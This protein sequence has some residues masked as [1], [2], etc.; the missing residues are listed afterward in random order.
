MCVPQS[1]KHWLILYED[2]SKRANHKKVELSNQISTKIRPAARIIQT[3]GSELIGDPYAAIIELVKNAFDAD[4]NKVEIVF[5]YD[6]SQEKLK[7]RIVDD[8]HGMTE[9]V[10]L[11][12]WLVP[13]TK[14]KLNIEKSP[15]GRIFQ[16]KK[17]IGRFAAALLGQEL[18]LNTT[19]ENHITTQILVDWDIFETSDFLDE[20]EILVEV[21]NTQENPGTELII[22]AKDEKVSQ[23][24]KTE[25]GILTKELRKLKSPFEIRDVDEFEI[26]LTFNNCPYDEY[27]DQTFEIESFPIIELFDYR[28]HGTISASGDLIATYENYYEENLPIANIKYSI[29][30][31]GNGSFAGPISFDFRV[32][33]RDREAISNLIDKGLIDPISRLAL[34]KR[35]AR[36]LLDEVYGVN[37]YREGFRIRP[38]GNGGI[39]WLDLDKRRIQ[40]PSMRVS[41]NQIVGFVE[42][43]SEQFSGLEEKSARD[44]LKE[45]P[46]FSGLKYMLQK[47]IL[48]LES[49]RFEYRKKTG[50]G[51]EN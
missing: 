24:G 31:D 39:D 28:I 32:F 34:G 23:W 48:Q 37:L 36:Q 33:D 44:G 7:I 40:N 10:V 4:A 45:T 19:D 50:K 18:L 2:S 6:S 5:D 11:N 20:V 49:R 15:R 9:D 27:N 8:G 25:L 1:W 43:K 13:A 21:Q 12:K 29:E 35:E 47:V 3:I 46:P 51:K 38:Y 16:G 30:L 17:G 26:N 42:I 41:N 22:F 14:N